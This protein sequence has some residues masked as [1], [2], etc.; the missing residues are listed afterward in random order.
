MGVAAL[1]C[2]YRGRREHFPIAQEHTPDVI[3]RIS[4]Q[5]GGGH[6]W[7][8]SALHTPR[9]TL[10]PWR[11][12][13]IT[14]APSWAE[15]WAPVLAALPFDREMVVVD[16]PGFA[17]SQPE[18][19][20]PDITVQAEALAPVLEPAPGQRVL[21]VGQSYGAAIA[22]LMAANQPERVD[23]LLLLSGF[24]GE[25]GP[26]ARLLVELG[27]RLWPVIPR[28]LRNAIT[29]VKGQRPQLKKMRKALE[30]LTL[31][32]HSVHG[33]RDDFAPLQVAQTLSRWKKGGLRFSIAPGAN[34]FLNDGPT[35]PLL[36]QLEA[37]IPRRGRLAPPK[38]V[39]SPVPIAAG[40]QLQTAC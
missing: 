34:H 27:A 7:I 5:A 36:E 24:F 28:D 6:P 15:Y 26:T 30:Q 25:L 2:S 33:D 20:I 12:V 32:I 23:S 10:A 14:G 31:P 3:E 39:E 40:Q 13:V 22:T 29:E 37:A 9:A 19:C 17:C 21:L 35:E 11:I 8:L 4:F 16:R 38:L 1:S 18:G